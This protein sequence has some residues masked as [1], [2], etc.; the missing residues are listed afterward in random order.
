MIPCISSKF[1]R[2][3]HGSDFALV[4][5]NGCHARADIHVAGKADPEGGVLLDLGL[6]ELRGQPC[7]R[8]RREDVNSWNDLGAGDVVEVAEVLLCGA[9]DGE[10]DGVA[11]EHSAV[12]GEG[13]NILVGFGDGN[14]K[15][16][17]GLIGF[18]F[19]RRNCVGHDDCFFG[20]VFDF[21]KKKIGRNKKS[22]HTL[23][24]G[25]RRKNGETNINL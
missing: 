6:D 10:D 12:E 7:V 3:R 14:D 5:E 2:L 8:G 25:R 19:G 13:A 1:E 20:V 11:V 21:K 18:G 9:G 17:S 15:R 24:G 22:K 16:N 4:V 23:E